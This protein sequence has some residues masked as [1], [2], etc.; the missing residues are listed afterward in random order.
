MKDIGTIFSPCRKYRYTLWRK[1]WDDQLFLNKDKS[2][3]F[4][5]FICLNP[6]TA[7]ETVNDP[8]VRRCINYA[9]AWGYDAMCM[10]NLFAFRATDPKDMLRESEPIGEENNL[11]LQRVAEQAGLIVAAWGNKGLSFGRAR[12]V[13]H[14]LKLP[15]LHCLKITN[16]GQPEHPL[17]LKKTLT[18]IPYDPAVGL[19]LGKSP[20]MIVVEEQT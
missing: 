6:S 10:T 18:P 2:P 1:W 5:Q 13:T 20:S 15:K 7:D 3:R 19:V 17:Y 12:N 4:V 14:Y 16:A 11:W 8:T 9:Q